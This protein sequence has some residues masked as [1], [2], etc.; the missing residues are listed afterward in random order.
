MPS[1]F[2]FARQPDSHFLSAAFAMRASVARLGRDVHGDAAIGVGPEA[3][4]ARANEGPMDGFGCFL[5][6]VLVAVIGALGYGTYA[7]YS[8]INQLKERVSTLKKIAGHSTKLLRSHQDR[9]DQ[10]DAERR[11][12]SLRIL[13]LE[14][15]DPRCRP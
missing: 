6:V 13:K 4:H 15:C 10:L 9:I 1:T 11:E 3:L 5:C 2:K 7:N 14:V 8:E 12:Q